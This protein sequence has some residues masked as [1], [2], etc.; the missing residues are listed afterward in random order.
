MTPDEQAIFAASL[1]AGVKAFL[2]W[3]VTVF[4]VWYFARKWLK[5]PTIGNLYARLVSIV[6]SL[7]TPDIMS[8]TRPSEP[9]ESAVQGTDAPS[10]APPPAIFVPAYAQTFDG[11]KLMR[12]YG[13]TREQ[14]R[15]V[16]KAFGGAFPN[17][18]WTQVAPSP[19]DGQ[20]VTPIA[21]RSTKATFHYDDPELQYVEPQS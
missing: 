5:L 13:L 14:A 18:M 12:G 21:G 15:E 2:S 10:L 11:C 17:E 19:S 3:A 4:A 6:S 20:T 9:S 8:N 7:S 16:V 1:D